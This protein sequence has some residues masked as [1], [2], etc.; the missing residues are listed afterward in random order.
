MFSLNMLAISIQLALANP[1]YEDI[2]SKFLEHFLNIT[3]AITGGT[4][5]RHEEGPGA[6]MRSGSGP[7]GLW[8][9]EDKFFYDVLR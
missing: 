7:T 3:A 1:A 2:S 9:D 8:D 4:R 5:E 6:G